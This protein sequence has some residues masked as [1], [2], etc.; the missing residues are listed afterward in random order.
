MKLHLLP[1]S[2][3]NCQKVREWRN[4]GRE[5]LRTPVMLTAEMQSTFFDEVAWDRQSANRYW[6]ILNSDWHEDGDLIGQCGLTDIQWENR[7]AEISLI[8]DPRLRGKGYG[9]E[10]VRLICE[11]GFR[12]MGLKTIFGEAY[13]CNSAWKFW[14]NITTEFRGYA[15]TLPDRKFWNE[16]WYDSLY[17]SWDVNC[18]WR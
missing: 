12:R 18:T 7:L 6:E 5:S 9:K 8:I 16:E 3:E 10:A 2:R 4:E 13:K 14:D 17:F 11:E 1:L 15:T